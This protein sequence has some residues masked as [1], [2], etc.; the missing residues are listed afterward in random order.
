MGCVCRHVGCHG[1]VVAEVLACADRTYTTER[2]VCCN[3]TRHI[4]ATGPRSASLPPFCLSCCFLTQGAVHVYRSAVHQSCANHNVERSFSRAGPWLMCIPRA[5]CCRT[6]DVLVTDGRAALARGALTAPSFPAWR[7]DCFVP[8]ME[9]PRSLG[10]HDRAWLH[11]DS[12]LKAGLYAGDAIEVRF[13]KQVRPKL[14]SVTLCSAQQQ[15][16]GGSSGSIAHDSVVVLAA[17]HCALH[18]RA[19][20]LNRDTRE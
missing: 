20:S 7:S 1:A 13:P 12:L 4:P 19:W 5:A 16:N 6:G 18:K 2:C 11:P 3:A 17:V 10:G 14:P 15:R 8:R 9:P